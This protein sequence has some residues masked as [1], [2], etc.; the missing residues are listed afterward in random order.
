MKKLILASTITL[1]ST[2]LHAQRVMVEPSAERVKSEQVQGYVST[3]DATKK[4]IDDAWSK[5]S[6]NLGKSR[7][8][9]EF[10]EIRDAVIDVQVYTGKSIFCKITEQ[11][12]GIKVWMGISEKDW[13]DDY[14][15]AEPFMERLLKEFSVKFYQDRVLAE[16]NES[17]KALRFAERQ[18]SRLGGEKND[19]EL[20]L[21]ENQR[22]K[23]QLERA[24]NN[25]QLQNH[26][27]IQKLE[28]NK[29]S[30]DSLAIS[31]EKIKR[32]IELQKEKLRQIN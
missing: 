11:G 27:L 7:S 5:F 1:I 13:G 17:E 9:G 8:S 19:L 23:M 22:E 3:L 15:K 26:V 29:K 4:E 21:E 18:Q 28:N 2:Y 25:N 14:S 12:K 10:I 31:L 6:K 16:I 20:K 32:M 30:Q 24:I